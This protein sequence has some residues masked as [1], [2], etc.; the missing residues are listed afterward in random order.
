[1][2]C[3]IVFSLLAVG[4]AVGQFSDGRYSPDQFQGRFDD[5]KYRPDNSGAYR[6]GDDGKYKGN[7][8]GLGSGNRRPLGNRP[9]GFGGFTAPV[10][11]ISRPPVQII[12][13]PQIQAAP[14]FVAPNRNNDYVSNGNQ[15][16]IKEFINELHED[17]YKYRY[18]TENNIDVAEAGQIENRGSDSEVLRAKGYYEFTADDGVRY[19]VDYI[20]DENGFQAEGAHLPTPPPIPEAILRSLEL[21]RQG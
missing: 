7:G 21:Q 8:D 12:S 16:G 14:V 20:A 5:G 4:C 19:R 17:G 11:V 10:Q 3:F 13:R 15:I 9:S 1:M 6:P 18:L 2:K